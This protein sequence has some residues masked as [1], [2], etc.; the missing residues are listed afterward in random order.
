MSYSVRFVQFRSIN[1]VKPFL[2]QSL[3]CVILLDNTLIKAESGKVSQCRT[4]E[5]PSLG[6]L[7]SSPS[8]ILSLYITIE[9]CSSF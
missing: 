7:S 9:E 3:L 5:F 6:V 4:A 8:K 1:L 2:S